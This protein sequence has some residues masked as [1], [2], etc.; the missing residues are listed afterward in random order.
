MDAFPVPSFLTVMRM[1]TMPCLITKILREQVVFCDVLSLLVGATHCHGCL[2][3]KNNNWY[4]ICSV[5]VI[6]VIFLCK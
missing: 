5:I 6:D 4:L 2:R 1:V 3:G